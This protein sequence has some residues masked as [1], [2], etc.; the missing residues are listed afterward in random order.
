MA[1][2]TGSLDERDIRMQMAANLNALEDG[3]RL[4]AEEYKVAASDGAGGS[5]DIL[6]EDHA[7]RFVI[8]EIKKSDATAREALHEL[9]KYVTLLRDHEGL[10]RDEIRCMIVSTDWH[11]LRIPFSYF[12]AMVDVHVQGVQLAIAADGTFSYEPVEPEPIRYLPSFSPEFDLFVY[13]TMK[14]RKE[15]LKHMRARA[16]NLPFLRCAVVLLD[17]K[18]E[19]A[20]SI[21]TLRSIVCLWRIDDRHYDQV[22]IVC[23]CKIGHLAP[24]AFPGWETEC[25]VLYWLASE[26]TTLGFPGTADGQRGT[27]EKVHNIL[28]EFSPTEVLQL[29]RTARGRTLNT[30]TRI[31]SLLLAVNPRLPVGRRNP[32]TFFEHIVPSNQKS[33]DASVSAFLDF[34]AFAPLWRSEAEAFLTEAKADPQTVNVSLEAFSKKHF[35]YAIH[36]ARAHANAELSSC[37]IFISNRDGKVTKGFVG[38]WSWDRTCPA[39]AKSEMCR[40]YESTQWAALSLLSAVDTKRYDD[41]FIA[42]GFRPIVVRLTEDSVGACVQQVTPTL[43]PTWAG[44]GTNPLREFVAA[45]PAYAEAVS[46]ELQAFG[47]IPT[48]PGSG[49]MLLMMGGEDTSSQ[50]RRTA[51]RLDLTNHVSPGRMGGQPSSEA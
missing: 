33:W 31:L 29:G 44:V 20:S 16:K 43:D 15:H 37:Q 11:E 51:D 46:N 50:P 1:N 14:E 18:P 32:H 45:N 41:A 4:I 5:I 42:H 23:G 38:V 19:V 25:D 3:L 17:P 8:I 10:G 7:G 49:V 48:Q 12:C 27:A 24:Y 2:G 26:D 9:S 35:F 34:I 28:S 47:A 22:E 36:Q 21:A 40:V 6:A 30:A 13:E 39:D